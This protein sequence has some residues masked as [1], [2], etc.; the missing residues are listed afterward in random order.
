MVSAMTDA[1]GEWRRLMKAEIRLRERIQHQHRLIVEQ[2]ETPGECAEMRERLARA[3]E[4]VS[5]L[6][7]LLGEF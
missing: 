4:L 2:L 6:K 1:L 3:D 7:G 5:A